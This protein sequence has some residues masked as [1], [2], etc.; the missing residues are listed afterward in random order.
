MTVFYADRPGLASREIHVWTARFSDHHHAISESRRLLSGEERARAA[1]FAF[2]HDRV[3]FIQ[4]HGIVRRILA[5]Y[6]GTDGDGNT[7]GASEGLSVRATTGAQGPPRAPNSSRLHS[8]SPSSA[9]AEYGPGLAGTPRVDLPGLELGLSA[10]TSPKTIPPAP[11]E[12]LYLKSRFRSEPSARQHDLDRSRQFLR[13]ML[14]HRSAENKIGT[15]LPSAAW[16]ESRET[17]NFRPVL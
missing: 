15:R 5:D 11:E 6:C 1:Q 2:E 7:D 8:S 4:T 16:Q 13:I 9:S 12:L 17:G 14:H 10:M 3:R